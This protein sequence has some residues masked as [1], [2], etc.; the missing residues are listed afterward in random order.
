MNNLF[1][2]LEELKDALL[3]NVDGDWSENDP[4]T[5]FSALADMLNN[6]LDKNL[7][8][9]CRE[10]LKNEG[11]FVENLW[12]TTDI[13]GTGENMDIEITEEQAKEIME[14]MGRRHDATIGVNWD[15][16]EAMIEEFFNK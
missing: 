5:E 10:F 15:F 9:D 16:I 2:Q 4:S 6:I 7:T 11:Y 1:K 12:T 14:L 13:I 8:S 3:T